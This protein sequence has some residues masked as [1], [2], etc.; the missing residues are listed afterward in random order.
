MQY[1]EKLKS[2]VKTH[3]QAAMAKRLNTGQS[4]ISKM[5]AKNAIPHVDKLLSLA[6][7]LE[8]DL[9]ALVIEL[10]EQSKINENREN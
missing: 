8:M 2:L 9:E 5:L 10:T 3:G 6:S 7:I 1:Q 4:Q